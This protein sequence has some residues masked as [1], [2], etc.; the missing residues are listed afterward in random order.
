MVFL[1]ALQDI[2]TKWP[3]W[4]KVDYPM[5]AEVAQVILIE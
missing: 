2:W 5:V 3:L 1:H 4:G